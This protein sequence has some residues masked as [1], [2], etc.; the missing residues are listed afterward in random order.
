MRSLVFPSS[1]HTITSQRALSGTPCTNHLGESLGETAAWIR[2][3]REEGRRR[4]LEAAP[5][6]PGALCPSW[7]TP[8]VECM[9][10][11]PDIASS[12]GAARIIQQCTSHHVYHAF[13]PSEAAAPKLTTASPLQKKHRWD[14]PR[15]PGCVWEWHRGPD[16]PLNTL[17]LRYSIST[18][19]SVYLVCF[20]FVRASPAVQSHLPRTCASVPAGPAAPSILLLHPPA[21]PAFRLPQALV[22]C[23]LHRNLL[24]P[25]ESP[26]CGGAQESVLPHA[27]PLF[28]CA[29]G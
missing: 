21:G 7:N 2:G 4:P 18:L 22:P 13:S 3:P 14:A 17:V 16:I 15:R 25:V 11:R 12:V 26:H 27:C 8:T 19:T 5:L 24:R 10:W 1:P 28:H 29:R 23:S 9:H 6:S 20:L